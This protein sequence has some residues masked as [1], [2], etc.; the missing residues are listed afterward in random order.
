MNTY[1]LQHYAT[2]K[3][4][5]LLKKYYILNFVFLGFADPPGGDEGIKEESSLAETPTTENKKTSFFAR[6]KKSELLKS[7]DDEPGKPLQM[8]FVQ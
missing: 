3:P 6:R 8:I 4:L 1:L 7:T 5:Y 2:W